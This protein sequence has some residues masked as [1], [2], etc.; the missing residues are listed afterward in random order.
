MWAGPNVFAISAQRVRTRNKCCVCLCVFLCVF[1]CK[2]LM[3]CSEAHKIRMHH[4]LT[5]RSSCARLHTL[6]HRFLAISPVTHSETM[7]QNC[8]PTA[9]GEYV[10][11]SV[12]VYVGLFA[13]AYAIARSRI[14]V[15]FWRPSGELCAKPAKQC[16]DSVP[17][18]YTNTSCRHNIF[19]C[20]D[21]HGDAMRSKS[22]VFCPYR[23]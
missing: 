19:N 6:L 14:P 12:F 17:N 21:L 15:S 7:R 4:Q 2:F 3:V 18:V 1:L 9:V 8:R 5:G 20:T 23:M 10:K 13:Y 11:C 16:P 22:T